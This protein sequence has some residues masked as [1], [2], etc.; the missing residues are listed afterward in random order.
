M[1]LGLLLAISC[2]I[3]WGLFLA[4]VRVLK[5]WEWE[6][7]W[8]VWSLF[9]A[10]IGPWLVAWWTVP[11]FADVYREVGFRILL[12]TS[13]IGG[14]SGTAG[15]LYSYSVP[16][17]GLGLATSLNAGASMAMSLLPLAVLHRDTIVHR[18]GMFTILGVLLAIVGTCLCG[19]G[20]RLRE[21]DADR[22]TNPAPVGKNNPTFLRCVALTL[23]S[24]AIGTG[25]N[26]AL[27]F[28]NPIFTVAHKYGSSS[29]GSANAFLAPY[30]LGACVSNLIYAGNL[31]RK[32]NS[33]SKFF[34]SGWLRCLVWSVLM[35]VFFLIGEYSYSGSVSLLGS[36]GAVIAWGLSVAT[37]I[38]TSGVWDVS[39][40]EWQGRAAREMALGVG[41]LMVAVVTLG[42]AQYFHRI[43]A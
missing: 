29:F 14:I 7:I 20:G 34:A 8:I 38:L 40:G 37:M 26:I 10:L 18:S 33:F 35:A 36:F 39:H 23:L 27:A 43:G 28:P 17:I 42:F 31:V 1:I 24:G 21:K 25:M 19:D 11:H 15:F 41:V 16:V 12:L 22:S 9:A 32:N 5:A 3:C 4:P 30:L 6:N 2:G 13:V